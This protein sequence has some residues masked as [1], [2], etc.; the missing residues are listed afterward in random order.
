MTDDDDDTPSEAIV[1]SPEK[2]FTHKFGGTEVEQTIKKIVTEAI[3]MDIRL[4]DTP[5]TREALKDYVRMEI[6]LAL[7]F[8]QVV[9]SPGSTT[10]GDE[11]MIRST[12]KLKMDIRKELYFDVKGEPGKE[13]FVSNVRELIEKKVIKAQRE[14]DPLDKPG[15]SR[16]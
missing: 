9:E 4:D 2:M 7:K 3:R 13:K 16:R 15:K 1:V 6:I 14:L 12:A 11:R 10:S 8:A 5:E